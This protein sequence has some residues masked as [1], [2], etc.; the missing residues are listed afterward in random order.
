MKNI[1]CYLED[2]YEYPEYLAKA[3]KNLFGKSHTVIVESIKEELT[4]FV[5]HEPVERFL[6]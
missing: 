5:E 2:C 3:L 4:E 1:N 6:K